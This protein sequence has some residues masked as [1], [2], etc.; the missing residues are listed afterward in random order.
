[1]YIT[2]IEHN[3]IHIVGPS[4]QIKT[5]IRSDAIR[6][7]EALSFGPDGWIYVSDSALSELVL[8]SREHIEDNQPYRIFRFQPGGQGVPGQ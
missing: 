5:L 4:R 2:D 8:Q 3:S 6:W 7:P 1:M